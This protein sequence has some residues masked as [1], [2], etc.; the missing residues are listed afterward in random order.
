MPKNRSKKTALIEDIKLHSSGV[1]TSCYLYA[2]P[3]SSLS[4]TLE[5]VGRDRLMC[6]K[7]KQRREGF[8]PTLLVGRLESLRNSSNDDVHFRG[9]L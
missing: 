2:H 7:W 5:A 9:D 4:T 8:D 1:T 6:A 3:Y